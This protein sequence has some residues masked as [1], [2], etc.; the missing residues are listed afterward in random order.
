MRL[1]D[2]EFYALRKKFIERL[3][4]FEA[5]SELKLDPDYFSDHE[6]AADEKWYGMYRFLLI[7]FLTDDDGGPSMLFLHTAVEDILD[8]EFASWTFD[9]TTTVWIKDHK[10]V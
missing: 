9:T 4:S 8:I 6:V 7:T 10:E 3:N 5:D 2:D 1:R